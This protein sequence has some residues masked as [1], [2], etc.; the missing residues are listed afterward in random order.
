MKKDQDYKNPAPEKFITTELGSGVFASVDGR[1]T[2]EEYLIQNQ[3]SQDDRK[4]GA[5]DQNKSRS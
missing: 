5:G 4:D 2:D 3:H 1:P